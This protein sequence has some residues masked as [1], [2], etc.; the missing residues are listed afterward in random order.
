ML[1]FLLVYCSWAPKWF[2]A[3]LRNLLSSEIY[4]KIVKSCEYESQLKAKNLDIKHWPKLSLK[5]AFVWAVAPQL[6]IVL[7]SWIQG[8]FINVRYKAPIMVTATQF[9]NWKK[10]EPITTAL[11]YT[12]HWKGW[13]FLR[14]SAAYILQFCSFTKL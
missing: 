9:L 10:Y 8:I 3:C 4:Y 6:R 5:S 11:Q 1:E 7:N 2:K 14:F 13:I 12:I